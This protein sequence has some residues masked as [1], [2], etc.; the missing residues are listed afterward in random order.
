MGS[1]MDATANTTPNSR[2]RRRLA[3]PAVALALGVLLLALAAPRLVA[4]LR[5]L[6]AR[7]VLWDVED[8]TLPAP[9]RL[10]AAAADL[11]AAAGWSADGQALQERGALLLRLGDV[12]AEAATAAGLA[13]APG[14][15]SAWARLARLRLARGDRAGAA[16][17]LRLSLLTGA[18]V[19]QIMAWRLDLGLDL[20]PTLDA[21]TRALVDR[22]I[23]LTWVLQPDII[24]ALALRPG[25][26][27]LVRE[28]LD[29]LSQQDMAHYIRLH[30]RYT[31]SQ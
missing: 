10:R 6:E 18:V 3:A 22:Q 27:G 29:A 21:D 15:P 11:A 19:P 20:R 4:A 7:A 23:R 2:S 24:A 17:A 12:Q 16:A 31:S 1:I 8:G 9:D 5:T 26:A 13:L 30:R 28:A 14:Q 25:S